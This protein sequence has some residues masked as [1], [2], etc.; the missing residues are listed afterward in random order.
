MNRERTP[1]QDPVKTELLQSILEE[2]ELRKQIAS[3]RRML[4]K[5]V[6]AASIS[7]VI[8]ATGFIDG[9]HLSTEQNQRVDQALKEV[10]AGKDTIPG[11]NVSD[12]VVN[13]P[14]QLKM[15]EEI[16][17]MLTARD[18]QKHSEVGRITRDFLAIVLGGIG[19]ALSFGELL[20]PSIERLQE[21][22]KDSRILEK[23]NLQIIQQQSASK[24]A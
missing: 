1:A 17:N 13:T 3:S 19:T 5:S 20:L 14:E 18:S 22:K 11:P 7:A 12:V 21:A 2:Q 24:S 15:R 4:L 8:A 6:S 10:Y 16:R 23:R 9:M